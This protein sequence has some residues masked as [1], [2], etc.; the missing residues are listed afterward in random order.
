MLFHLISYFLNLFTTFCS[1]RHFMTSN[2]SKAGLEPFMTSNLFPFLVNG[3]LMGIQV[4]FLIFYGFLH[5]WHNA[6]A[7]LLRFADRKF[8]SRWWESVKIGDYYRDWNIIVQDWLYSYVY[9]PIMINTKS[10]HLAAYS[11]LFVSALF[12]EYIIGLSMG[13]LFPILFGQFAF[14]GCKS[15]SMKLNNN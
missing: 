12:H 2:F 10:K 13:F 15:K 7:E 9:M 4:T 1:V 3:Y 14:I 5:S 11:V 6:F 8:Y